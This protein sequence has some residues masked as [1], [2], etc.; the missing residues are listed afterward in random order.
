MHTYNI[1]TDKEIANKAKTLIVENYSNYDSVNG[2]AKKIGTNPNKLKIVFR[3]EYGVSLFQFSRTQRIE[4]AK[5][6]LSETNYTLPVIGELVGY[7]EGNNFQAAFKSVV[8][9]APGAYRK[10]IPPI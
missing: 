8:G 10:N 2:L 7:T 1:P 6:L 5:K 4:Y 9:I 3:K